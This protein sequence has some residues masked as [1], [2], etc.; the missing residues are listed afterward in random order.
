M[1]FYFLGIVFSSVEIVPENELLK[2]GT[3]YAVIVEPEWSAPIK[4]ITGISTLRD[5]FSDNAVSSSVSIVSESPL[6]FF[7]YIN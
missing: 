6:R 3:S 4:E 2:I 7:F 1:N 5:P